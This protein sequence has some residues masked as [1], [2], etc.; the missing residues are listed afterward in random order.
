MVFPMK[1]I[2][3]HMDRV[4]KME[5]SQPIT[6]SAMS[7]FWSPAEAM[8]EWEGT[9]VSAV[10]LSKVRFPSLSSSTLAPQRHGSCH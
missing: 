10:T 5:S 1:A 6:E 9:C 3:F 2:T 7:K 4:Q 8:I